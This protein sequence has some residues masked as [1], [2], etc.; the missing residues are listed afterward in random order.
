F[1]E[2]VKHK[3]ELV[4]IFT[5]LATPDYEYKVTIN[6]KYLTIL[7]DV[8]KAEIGDYLKILKDI[9]K[10]VMP[11]FEEF[12]ESGKSD[13]SGESDEID[14][15]KNIIKQINTFRKIFR[16]TIICGIVSAEN[17]E[18]VKNVENTSSNNDIDE[19][20]KRF[21]HGATEYD[22]VIE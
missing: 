18:N 21:Q 15:I 16:F 10:D 17:A 5:I 2:W 4:A 3:Q 22:E 19:E 13:V 7:K 20:I 8:T 6:Y 9:L 1:K 12:D 11:R 14:Q